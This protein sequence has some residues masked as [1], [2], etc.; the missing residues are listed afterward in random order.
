MKMLCDSELFRI[1]IQIRC[2]LSV[3]VSISLC[4]NFEVIYSLCFPGKLTV[5]SVSFHSNNIGQSVSFLGA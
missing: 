1:P 5:I 2:E 4:L 3:T